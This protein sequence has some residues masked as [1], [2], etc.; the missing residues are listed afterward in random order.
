MCEFSVRNVSEIRISTDSGAMHGGDLMC[1]QTLGLFD[2]DG[3]SL[4]KVVLYLDDPDMALQ[5]DTRLPS[6]GCG[7]AGRS[8]VVWE[9]RPF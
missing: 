6:M 5:V 3:N 2:A 1:R 7:L 8:A 4:G 9:D